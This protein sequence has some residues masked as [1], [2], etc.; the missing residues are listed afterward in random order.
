[1]CMCVVRNIGSFGITDF[2][3]GNVVGAVIDVEN[4]LERKMM[5]LVLKKKS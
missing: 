3:H 1:M 2:S 5:L 4:F